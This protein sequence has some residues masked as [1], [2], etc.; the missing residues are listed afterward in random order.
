MKTRLCDVDLIYPIS[1]A[2]YYSVKIEQHEHVN[3]HLPSF[4]WTRAWGNNI[5]QFEDL[6]IEN[7]NFIK[8]NKEKEAWKALK[9]MNTKNLLWNW[10]TNRKAI[11][12]VW[13]R[14]SF[15]MSRINKLLWR[16]IK[17]HSNGTSFKFLSFFTQKQTDLKLSTT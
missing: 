11:L 1:R 7:E 13:G 10:I 14:I 9:W 16:H 3:K 15:N 6:S 5:L 2:D 8:K 4:F 12:G 17:H